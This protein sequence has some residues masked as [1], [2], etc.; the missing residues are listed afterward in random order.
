MIRQRGL[1]NHREKKKWGQ[2]EQ[3]ETNNDYHFMAH[4][5]PFGVATAMLYN[6]LGVRAPAE[7]TG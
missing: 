1:S 5:Y 3:S 7:M 6:A 4:E 2:Q